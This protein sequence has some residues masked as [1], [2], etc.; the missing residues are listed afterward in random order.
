MADNYLER[1]MEEYRS[2]KGVTYRHRTTPTGARPGTLNVKF[3]S[4]RVLVTGGASGIGRAI[5]KAFCD[6][7]CRV[8][9]CDIDSKA[10][11]ATAQA[12]G[13]QFHP[14][15]VRDA[16]ALERCMD[17]LLEAWGD[18][19]VIVNNVGV[20]AFKP[21]EESTLEEWDDI[22][23]INVRPV[24]ITSRKLAIHRRD[25]GGEPHYGRI[26][27]MASTRQSMSEAGTEAYSAS[28]GAVDSL[29]HAL[30]M[31]LAPLGITV[32][33]VSP[34]WI[35][36]GDYDALSEADHSQHPSRRVGR[37]DD[38]ARACIFIALP[39]NDFLNG[40]NIVIDGGMTRK[41][42]YV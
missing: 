11:A 18:I 1:K 25:M 36:T 2:G 38:I 26:I 7:G 34:G 19:D 8:A 15:D 22:M 40:E 41:M 3:P 21:L 20:S 31:S 32:N 23:S 14:V 37:V 5:V 28:K 29:T 10:G 4:R 24:Y 13:A 17:R 35:E 6:A 33:S 42:I 9:F 12:T 39:D 30:M 16:A 27:N